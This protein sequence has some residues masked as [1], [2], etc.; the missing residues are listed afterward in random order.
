LRG[1]EIPLRF[2][3]RP[4]FQTVIPQLNE[5]NAFTIY[6]AN[7]DKPSYPLIFKEF[8]EAYLPLIK[9]DEREFNAFVK[10]I[11]SIIAYSTEIEAFER[12]ERKN[13]RFQR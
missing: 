12:A 7:R 13:R 4:S 11:S 1:L 5:L 8:Y 6:Q 3:T 2:P 9:S 10:F